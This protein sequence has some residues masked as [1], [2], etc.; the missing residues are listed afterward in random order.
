MDMGMT[1]IFEAINALLLVFLLSVY[2]KN[3]VEMKTSLGFGLII[4]SA[5][6]L[7]QNLLA[8]YFHASMIEYY[9]GDVV[10]HAFILSAAETLALAVLAWVTW[11]E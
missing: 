5:F 9:S 3:Y 10:M 2:V 8:A 4:F 1:I 6:L 11:R 7:A